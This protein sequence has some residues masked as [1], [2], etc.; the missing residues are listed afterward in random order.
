MFLGHQG[1]D[2]G[3]SLNPAQAKT[4]CKAPVSVVLD[5]M[6]GMSRDLG[7]DVPKLGLALPV[8]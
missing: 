7:R 3:M 5:G 8:T 1:P 4:L 6:A 2:V